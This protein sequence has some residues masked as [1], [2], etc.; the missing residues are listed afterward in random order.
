MR[1]LG[2]SSSILATDL[3]IVDYRAQPRSAKG[4]NVYAR[5]LFA[6]F[7][8]HTATTV[9]TRSILLPQTEIHRSTI[10]L[11]RFCIPSITMNSQYSQGGIFF[12]KSHPPT[13]YRKRRHHQVQVESNAMS[14]Q[15]SALSLQ[16][17][18]KLYREQQQQS[19]LPYPFSALPVSKNTHCQYDSPS[20][21]SPVYLRPLKRVKPTKQVC[22]APM[23]TVITT[24]TPSEEDNHNSWYKA[25]D[26]R[27]FELLNR[28]TVQTI[29]Q[30]GGVVSLN[31][32]DVSEI[33][34]EQFLVGRKR[35]VARRLRSK[36]RVAMVLE[37]YDVQRC[38]G[39]FDPEM[40]RRISQ[41]FGDDQA[42]IR[43]ERLAAENQSSSSASS[44]VVAIAGNIRNATA[45]TNI[46]F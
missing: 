36:Q 18:G 41:R 20:S 8:D 39:V 40:V 24:S 42:V 13:P 19:A 2:G 7:R 4:M 17:Q 46:V 12:A 16:W 29:Y 32:N 34:L 45:R 23:A 22:F 11:N 27:S 44:T 25:E 5:Q 38:N 15:S 26:Y 10:R 43:A 14:F 37:M 21:G 1:F 28:R 9:I 3:S 6:F 31:P 30:A 33:G 35:M